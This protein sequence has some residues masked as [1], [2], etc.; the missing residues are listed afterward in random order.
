VVTQSIPEALTFLL[1]ATL[2]ISVGRTPRHELLV[3][4]M[5]LDLDVVDSSGEIQRAGLVVFV[6][7]FSRA[8]LA[9]LI[10]SDGDLV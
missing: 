4:T 8:I 9:S 5:P 6:D 7:R 10:E 2:T 3:F 1:Q